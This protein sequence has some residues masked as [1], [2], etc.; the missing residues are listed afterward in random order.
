MIWDDKADALLIRLWDEGCSLAYVANG[1]KQAGYEV[2]RNAVSGR[3]HRLTS[4]LFKRK[5][6]T[7]TKT[8]KVERKPRE[9][10]KPVNSVK[11]TSRRPVTIEELDD[12][13]SHSGVEYLEQQTWGCKAIMPSRG[14]QWDLQRV[15]GK[16]RCLDYNGGMSSY[17]Q[18]HFRMFTNPVPLSRR[19]HHA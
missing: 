4:K 9:R 16:P 11:P 19:Q 7:A 14:G 18:T 1:L 2:S 13:T 10:S 8:V 3:K 15:C 6:A 12:I 5:T 17:C